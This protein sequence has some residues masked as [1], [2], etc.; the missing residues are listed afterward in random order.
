MNPYDRQFV[1]MWRLRRGNGFRLELRRPMEV[2]WLLLAGAQ[3]IA[4]EKP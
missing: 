3:L 2:F 1:V 4:S